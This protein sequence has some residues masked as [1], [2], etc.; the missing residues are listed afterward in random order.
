M[1]NIR[2][3]A[4]VAGGLAAAL[5]ALLLPVASIGVDQHH[6]GC[7][8]KPA[9]DVLSGQV[10]FRDSFMQYGAM[11]CYLQVLALWIQPTLLSIRLLTVAAYVLTLLA[12]YAAWRLILPRSLAGVAGLLFILFVPVCEKD[13]WDHQYYL[14][15]PW[16]SVYAMLFQ[17][18]GLYALFRVI[19][20]ERPESWGLVLGMATACVF[21]FRQPVGAMMLGSLMVIWPALHWAG[22][23]PATSSKRAILGRVVFGLVL[24]H[25]LMFGGMAVTGA[26]PAWWYQNVVWPARW[27]QSVDWMD[28]LPFSIHPVAAADM[29]ALGMALAVP[30]VVWRSRP[31]WFARFL[32]VYG[33][34][35][36]AL[37]IWQRE[38]LIRALDLSE[39]GWALVI[40]LVIAGQAGLSVR[41]AFAGTGIG[42]P[43]EYYMVS[44]LA[45]LALGSLVQYYPMADSWH[46]FYSLADGLPQDPRDFTR[47]EPTFGDTAAAGGPARDEGS[48]GAGPHIGPG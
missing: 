32:P 31:G 20:G 29:L 8:L 9:L 25:A 27:S 44:A 30:T 46:I 13:Y 40:P 45:A 6:D 36:G 11:S 10:L 48:T 42:R 3:D 17:S 35:L 23:T 4:L 37:L 26:L 5:L 1:S 47:D 33:L 28:T 24:V 19:R 34:A 12:L 18:L 41:Q 21:W 38:A 43:G 39:G 16:S 15:L 22:W 7:M 14:L 2:H